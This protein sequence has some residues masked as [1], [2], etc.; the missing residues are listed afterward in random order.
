[1]TKSIIILTTLFI[2]AS[3]AFGGNP[4]K[5]VQKAFEQKFAKAEKVAWAKENSKEW[6]AGFTLNGMNVSAN[7]SNAG[8][9][10]ETESE[11]PVSELPSKVSGS[12]KERFPKW[13]IAGAYKIESSSK[14]VTYEA[15]LKYGK[16]KKEVVLTEDGTV[17]K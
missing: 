13:E 7:F 3:L 12:I 4:Q 2:F 16:K 5:A 11:I 8:A 17:K 10:M 14:A 1:M 9:W 6:E 15:D